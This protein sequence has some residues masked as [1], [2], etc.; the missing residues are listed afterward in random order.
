MDVTWFDAEKVANPT[1]LKGILQ[2]IE[3][4]VTKTK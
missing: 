1:Y 2:Y 3:N 4:S